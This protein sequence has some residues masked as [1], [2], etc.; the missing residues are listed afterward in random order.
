M[1]KM[2][3]RG[4]FNFQVAYH[5]GI[6]CSANCHCAVWSESGVDAGHVRHTEH[7]RMEVGGTDDFSVLMSTQNTTEPCK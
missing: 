1:D 5:Q 2:G 4:R 3:W 6:S 7:Y